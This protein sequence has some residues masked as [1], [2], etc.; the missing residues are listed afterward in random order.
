MLKLEDHW[1][2][3]FFD[4][5]YQYTWILDARGSVI[6]VNRAAQKITGF[7]PE[8]VIGFPLW[9]VPW[10]GLSRHSRQTIKWAV[11]QAMMGKAASHE[12]EIRQRGQPQLIVNLGSVSNKQP[13][14]QILR[15]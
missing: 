6:K 8:T 15:R 1:F 2:E 11:N 14:R 9:L 7:S 3:E 10:P 4:A 5:I 12:L 13:K